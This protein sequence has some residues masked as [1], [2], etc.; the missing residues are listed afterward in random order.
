VNPS[1]V[2]VTSFGTAVQLAARVG[3]AASEGQVL[4]TAVVKDLTA[5]KGLNWS[6]AL[7]IDAKGFDAPIAVFALSIG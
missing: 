4:A 6:S 7:A 1:N 2:T 3:D 5:G